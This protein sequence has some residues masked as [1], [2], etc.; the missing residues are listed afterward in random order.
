VLKSV[1]KWGINPS[2]SSDI[3]L[4]IYYVG[5][6]IRLTALVNNLNKVFIVELVRDAQFFSFSLRSKKKLACS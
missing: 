1:L 6:R 5:A 2:T 4:L 3:D